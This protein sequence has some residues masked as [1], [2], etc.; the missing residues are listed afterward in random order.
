MLYALI[1]GDKAIKSKSVKEITF[2]IKV[3]LRS[4]GNRISKSALKKTIRF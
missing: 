3:L 2:I 4:I 1:I